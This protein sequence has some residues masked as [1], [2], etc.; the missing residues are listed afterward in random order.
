MICWLIPLFLVFYTKYIKAASDPPGAVE[1]RNV[2]TS[3]WHENLG[4]GEIVMIT[5]TILLIEGLK[6]FQFFKIITWP[7]H[8][9]TI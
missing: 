5:G 1:R 6:W 4:K 9:W 2:P 8:P 3:P 7:L